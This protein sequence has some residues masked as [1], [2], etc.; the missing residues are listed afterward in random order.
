[1][2]DNHLKQS[3]TK[4]YLGE[5]TEKVLLPAIAELLKPLQDDIEALSAKVTTHLELSDKRYLQLKN[6]EKLLA[7]WI[8]QIADKTGVSIDLAELEKF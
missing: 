3:V 1:M 5:F 6:R 8:K 4:E 2:S 7:K